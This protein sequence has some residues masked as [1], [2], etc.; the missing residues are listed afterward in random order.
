MKK[1]FSSK[2]ILHLC[3][4]VLLAVIFG[5]FVHTAQ[6]VGSCNNNMTVCDQVQTNDLG[7]KIPSLADILTFVIRTFFFI[8]GLV[9]FVFMLLGAFA[10]ITSGGDKDAIGAAREKIQ[11]AIIG[12]I[13]IVVVL[14]IMWTL[15]NV[16]FK[17]RLCIGLTCPVTI[18]GLIETST[19]TYECCCVDRLGAT[20]GSIDVYNNET[21]KG[22]YPANDF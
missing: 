20:I 21:C 22:T 5:T 19:G 7:F 17:K 2:L 15:E 4:F 16:V 9:A 12:L 18:P 3:S 6:A 1:I 11:A 13:L 8:A 10:W 14:A